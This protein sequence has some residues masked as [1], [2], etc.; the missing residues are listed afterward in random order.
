MFYFYIDFHFIRAINPTTKQSVWCGLIG[1]TLHVALTC[2][3]HVMIR[4]VPQTDRLEIC[5]NR[6]I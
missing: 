5:A 6:A 4:R 1:V 3:V 2:S